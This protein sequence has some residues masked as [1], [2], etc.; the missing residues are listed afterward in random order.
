MN[1]TPVVGIA[2]AA[3]LVGEEIGPWQVG[4]AAMVLAGVALTTGGRA[5]A[6]PP[7]RG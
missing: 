5:P 1:V 4:G 2:T 7:A 3:L 6:R